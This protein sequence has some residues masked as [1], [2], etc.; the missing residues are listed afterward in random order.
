[1][2]G[3]GAAGP[4][5]MCPPRGRAGR[6]SPHLRRHDRDPACGCGAGS[7]TC[8]IGASRRDSDAIGPQ[9]ES[10]C[11]GPIVRLRVVRQTPCSV[12]ID[13]KADLTRL[14]ATARLLLC[15]RSSRRP[16]RPCDRPQHHSQAGLG[17]DQ[18]A[19][20]HGPAVPHNAPAGDDD[21]V[22]ALEGQ[23]RRFAPRLRMFRGDDTLGEVPR[24]S[25]KSPVRRAT[26]R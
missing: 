26:E 17:Q 7:G 4:A 1:M 2:G 18:P 24:A 6:L 15:T 5:S 20:G 8:P 21:R 22:T 25:R 9:I 11:S 14:T 16:Q 23:P 10:R 13:L 12:R 19:G 3:W